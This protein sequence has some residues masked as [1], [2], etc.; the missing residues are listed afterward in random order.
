LEENNYVYAKEVANH[1]YQTYGVKYTTKGATK[2]LHRLDFQYKK[3]KLVPGKL[4]QEKQ[5]EFRLQYNLLKSR[6]KETEAIYF[7]DAAHPQV[8]NKGKMR[9]D[10][11]ECN[12]NLTYF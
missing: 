12:K 11:K 5:E 8:S 10:K 4:D 7:M 1:I 2:L 3:P 6:L 9:L